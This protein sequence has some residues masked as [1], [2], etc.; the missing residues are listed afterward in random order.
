MAKKSSE[1]SRQEKRRRVKCE[2]IVKSKKA[3]NE[4]AKLKGKK[5]NTDDPD[6]K[7]I[8]HWDEAIR[9][10]FYKPIKK[11]ISIRLDADVIE[12]F[13]THSDKYQTLIN[14]ACIEYI[15]HHT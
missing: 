1:S 13:K 10:K 14:K 6:A 3:K 15:K 5:V 2:D 9:G 11:Q 8:K 4:I 7:E 12:W